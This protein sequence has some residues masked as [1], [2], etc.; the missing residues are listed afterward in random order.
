MS[1]TEQQQQQRTAG[2]Q[3]STSRLA[4]SAIRGATG[5]SRWAPQIESET[6]RKRKRNAT[7][8]SS[9]SIP[10]H[11]SSS[12]VPS[13]PP[14]PPLPATEPVSRKRKREVTEDRTPLL[15]AV[16]SPSPRSSFNSTR[17]S[18]FAQAVRQLSGDA[19]AEHSATVPDTS[20][21]PSN[22]QSNELPQL[23]DEATAPTSAPIAS[24]SALSANEQP[25]EVSM[26]YSILHW[27]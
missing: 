21:V 14:L 12:R 18:L 7:A 19:T 6:T 17:P 13:P 8:P 3:L 25:S 24:T 22:E 26:F 2:R 10:P 4:A 9:S 1:S 23:R 11:L 27:L 5:P 20:A 15:E 16:Y